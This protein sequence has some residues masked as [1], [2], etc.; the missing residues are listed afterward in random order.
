MKIK[1][2]NVGSC[3]GCDIEVLASAMT[4]GLE[5]VDDPAE[6]DLYLV[7][8]SLTAPNA[9]R[10]KSLNGRAALRPVILVGACAV[11]QRLFVPAAEDIDQ[12]EFLD[13]KRRRAVCGCPPSPREIA[14][15][16]R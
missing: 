4:E 12:F 2:F 15:A 14:A 1:V 16:C 6:A 3:N 9:R 10:L 13:K 5:L 7:T 11:S 8:G